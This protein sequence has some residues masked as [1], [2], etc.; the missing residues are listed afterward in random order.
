LPP[1][2]LPCPETR[3]HRRMN[4]SGRDADRRG[5]RLPS[6]GSPCSAASDGG[7][8][9]PRSIYGHRSRRIPCVRSRGDGL[10]PSPPSASLHAH[11]LDGKV[12]ADSR[13][14]PSARG[15][16]SGGRRRLAEHDWPR[17]LGG[18]VRLRALRRLDAGAVSSS[19]AG[20]LP[21]GARASGLTPARRWL[22]TPSSTRSSAWASSQAG[23]ATGSRERARATRLGVSGQG[24]PERL[25]V[26]PAAA[27]HSGVTGRPCLRGH[28]P[29]DYRG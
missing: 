23:G 18:A 15:K 11:L 5:L 29:Q 3:R 16:P 19:E 10:S 14:T 7:R 8:A 17:P 1:A 21:D 22:A 28:R 27:R 13:S 26:R 25:F 4:D 24:P 20:R 6:R 12:P 2:A 9:P